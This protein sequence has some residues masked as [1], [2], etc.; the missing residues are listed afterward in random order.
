[1]VDLGPARCILGMNID[2]TESGSALY[3]TSYIESL[4]WCFKMTDAYGVDT[5]IDTHE[6][7]DIAANDTDKTTDQTEY[8]AIV[9]LLMYAAIGS[10]PDISYAVGL[11]C[12]CNAN[13]YT[14]H[15]TAVKRVLRYHK[16]TKD[17]KQVYTTGKLNGFI[18][19]N[20]AKS[21][22][23]KS[24]GGYVFMFGNAAILWSSK[25]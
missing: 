9:G 15:L 8:L 12:S 5:P 24:I 14:R 2:T 3:Q 13:P 10:C 19:S 4:L 1:M 21:L 16:K 18:D 25:K 17:L 6:S 7:L 22:D 11:L 23:R 20:W